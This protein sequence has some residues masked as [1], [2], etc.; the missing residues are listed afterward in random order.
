[1]TMPWTG[2]DKNMCIDETE[3]NKTKWLNMKLKT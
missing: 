2:F 1:M 3:I